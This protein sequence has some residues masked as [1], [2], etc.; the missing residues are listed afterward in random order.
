MPCYRVIVRGRNFRLNVA[1]KWEKFGFCTPRFAKAPDAVL[2]EEVAL[3]A[4]LSG[5]SP[6]IDVDLHNAIGDAIT[7][8][9]AGRL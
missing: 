1:G 3:A 6:G 9:G 4:I 8:T 2:A 5:C 7:V